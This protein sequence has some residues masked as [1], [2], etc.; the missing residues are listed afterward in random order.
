[1]P[2][3]AGRSV[4][5][6]QAMRMLGVSKRTVYYRIRE[7]RLRTIRVAGRVAA[8]PHGV[9]SRS[10]GH[11]QA[12]DRAVPASVRPSARRS[13]CPAGDRL[14][15]VMFRRRLA[16]RVRVSL[17][18]RSHRGAGRPGPAPRA[19]VGRPRAAPR[20]AD[21]ANRV[22]HR[23]GQPRRDCGAGRAP[24]PDAEAMA[25]RGRRPRRGGRWPAGAGRRR[26]PSRTSRAT[27][28]CAGRWR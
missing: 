22:G 3:L 9:D 14:E 11:R 18:A 19:A 21:R 7:G 16:R 25:L 27:W 26:Q 13:P 1:M 10:R 5:I 6:D 8:R 4:F 15:A 20:L 2:D 12:A 24:R 23:H 17:A 28:P